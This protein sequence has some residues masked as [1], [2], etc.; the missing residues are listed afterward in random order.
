MGQANPKDMKGTPGIVKALAAK[1]Q[2][3][4]SAARRT[5]GKTWKQ[6]C[7]EIGNLTG[8]EAAELCERLAENLGDLKGLTLK[9]AVVLNA[10]TAL[11]SSP[12]PDS[13]LLGLIMD[14]DEGKVPQASISASIDIDV[15]DWRTVAQE[16]GVDPQTVLDEFKLRELDA[17]QREPESLELGPGET[18]A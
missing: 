1:G 3:G 18:G 2:N 4:A 13:K 10:Y 7:N 14:R 17:G 9:E 6:L 16:L 15:K 12:V 8:E 11:V 5:G